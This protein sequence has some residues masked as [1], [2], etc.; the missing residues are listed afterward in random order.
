MDQS[1]S[2]LAQA[3]TA[4]F[5]EFN[6]IRATTVALPNGESLGTFMNIP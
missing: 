1:I 2:F 5:I 6:P 4:K 3:G